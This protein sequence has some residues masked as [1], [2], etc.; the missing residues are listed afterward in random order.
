MLLES[1]SFEQYFI[2]L[3]DSLAKKQKGIVAFDGKNLSS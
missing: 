2:S 3:T 1:V